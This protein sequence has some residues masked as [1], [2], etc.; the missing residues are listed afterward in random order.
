[1]P[2]DAAVYSTTPWVKR[3][4]LINKKSFGL[5]IFPTGS[6]P[7]GTDPDIEHKT[8]PGDEFAMAWADK[9]DFDM[10]EGYKD[11][12]YDFVTEEQWKLNA[13]RFR[14]DAGKLCASAN[15]VLMCKP[16]SLYSA[17]RWTDHLKPVEERL[18]SETGLAHEEA[19]KW[20]VELFE[21]Q[22]GEAV[23]RKNK[24]K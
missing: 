16:F 6:G 20:G 14:W 21:T 10:L 4:S 7:S 9:T 22:D 17:D 23:V 11:E 3:D 12:G 24:R 1:M 18:D 5:N 8:R 13:T 2:G 19:A 15:L